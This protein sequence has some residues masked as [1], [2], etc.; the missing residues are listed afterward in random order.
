M[1][2]AKSFKLAGEK[3]QEALKLKPDTP[4]VLHN[5][6]L[7]YLK[8]GK[9]EP[10]LKDFDRVIALNPNFPRAYYNKGQALEQLGRKDEATQA[11]RHF[12]KTGHPDGDKPLLEKTLIILQGMGAM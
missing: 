10:A 6:G 4:E 9:A 1:V 8:L 2:V 3:Y 11:Y 5:R 7:A 12:L